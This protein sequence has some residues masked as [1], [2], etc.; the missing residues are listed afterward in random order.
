MEGKKGTLTP[1]VHRTGDRDERG[2][3]EGRQ[4]EPG[5]ALC[6]FS[7]GSVRSEDD[8]YRMPA[9]IEEVQLACK[10]ER[11]ETETGEGY[12]ADCQQALGVCRPS[13]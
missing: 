11:Q 8:P 7:E 13:S 5:F 2:A 10:V 1:V 6:A 4:G 9:P 12:W 3:S